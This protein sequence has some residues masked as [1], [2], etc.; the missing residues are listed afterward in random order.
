MSAKIQQIDV[1]TLVPL[2]ELA[3]VFPDKPE[4]EY[5]A[6]KLAMA[7]AKEIS[8]PLTVLGDGKTVYKGRNRLRAAK[9]LFADGCPEFKTVPCLI[10]PSSDPVY[11]AWQEELTSRH[12]SATQRAFVAFNVNRDAIL[13]RAGIGKGESKNLLLDKKDG[14]TIDQ[15]AERCGC[16]KPYL[17]EF[18]ELYG[19]FHAQWDVV[20]KKVWYGG[21][22]DEVPVC[23]NR[24]RPSLMGMESTTGG[25]AA[26]RIFHTTTTGKVETEK[27]L[28]PRSLKSLRT[29]FGFW[30]KEPLFHT[31][32]IEQWTGLV[33]D[34][35]DDLLRVTEQAIKA[36]KGTR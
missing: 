14:P 31:P 35:P 33:A 13:K 36:R 30:G 20:F 27:G 7:M 10:R 21:D 18:A 32:M 4:A 23:L 5:Q 8:E 25:K 17:L 26:T 22:V 24:I 28:F 9:E 29:C 2:A 19:E 16:S 1:S 12:W 15:I 6:L 11:D 3:E 34:M